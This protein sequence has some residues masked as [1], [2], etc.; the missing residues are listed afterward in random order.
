MELCEILYKNHINKN[1]SHTLYLP[2][3][4]VAACTGILG[5]LADAVFAT[6]ML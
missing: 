6:E 4:T 2:K 3:L 1:I 5:K